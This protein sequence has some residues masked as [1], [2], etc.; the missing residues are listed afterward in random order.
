MEPDVSTSIRVSEGSSPTGVTD[1]ISQGYVPSWADVGEDGAVMYA[2]TLFSDTLTS[3]MFAY[4]A[5]FAVMLHKQPSVNKNE[6]I[7]AKILF[8][9]LPFSWNNQLNNNHCSH[10]YRLRNHQADMYVRSTDQPQVNHQ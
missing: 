2:D 9:F 4:S 10:Y 1:N 3:D 6:A 7:K 8:I 5:A